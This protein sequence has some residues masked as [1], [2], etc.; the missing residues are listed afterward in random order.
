MSVSRLWTLIVLVASA[1]SA[2]AGDGFVTGQVERDGDPRLVY[3]YLVKLPE[4][5]TDE[6]DR[7]WPLILYLHGGGSPT[8][9]GLRRTVAPLTELPAVVVAPTCAASPRGWRY[10]NWD[11][12][13]LGDLVEEVSAQH[14]VDPSRRAVIGFSMGGSAAWELPFYQPALFSKSVVLAGVCHPWSLRHYPKI[15]VWAFVGAEDFMRKEQQ[16]TITSA[17]RFEVDVVETVWAGRD[18]GGIH[19]AAMGHAPMLQWLVS[20]EDLRSEAPPTEASPAQK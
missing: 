16:E 9:E 14:R 20:D 10:M 18:H 7:T 5:Y 4:G 6:P 2:V 1:A 8:P 19:R 13:I 17:R 11:W 15:P 3:D 12:W